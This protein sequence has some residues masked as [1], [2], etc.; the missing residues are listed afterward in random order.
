MATSFSVWSDTEITLRNV[1]FRPNLNL[2]R[3]YLT[4]SLS[5]KS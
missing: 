4:R 3:N 1:L 5:R 2:N